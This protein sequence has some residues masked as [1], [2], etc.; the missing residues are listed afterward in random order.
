[1]WEF[2]TAPSAIGSQHFDAQINVH[3]IPARSVPEYSTDIL[4]LL[5]SSSS[6]VRKCVWPCVRRKGQQFSGEGRGNKHPDTKHKL[7]RKLKSATQ[8]ECQ[9]NVKKFPDRQYPKIGEDKKWKISFFRQST[10]F[11]IFVVTCRVTNILPKLVDILLF[12]TKKTELP[13]LNSHFRVL[14]VL[15]KS[16]QKVGIMWRRVCITPV[17]QDSATRWRH[18]PHKM[19]WQH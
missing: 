5:N 18:S 19:G 3:R 1:M 10:S 4:A 12:S 13:F 16:V 7:Q 8:R 11:N 14:P 17:L 6:N 9:S 15:C 2:A